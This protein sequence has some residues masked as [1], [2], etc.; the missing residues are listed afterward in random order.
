MSGQLDLFAPLESDKY[1]HA[2]KRY[3]GSV[4]QYRVTPKGEPTVADLLHPGDIVT[5]NYNTGPYR[6]VK[7]TL[8]EVPGCPPCY[9]LRMSLPGGKDARYFINDLVAVNRRLLKLFV[10]NKDEV[11]ITTEVTNAGT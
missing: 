4:N 8:V 9:S 6:I 3:K 5:T 7:I 10:A 1:W 11:F 2:L